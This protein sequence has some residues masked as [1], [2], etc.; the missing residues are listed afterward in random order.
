MQAEYL[1]TILKTDFFQ[2]TIEEG[3]NWSKSCESVLNQTSADYPLT[4]LTPERG[5][6][7]GDLQ[8]GLDLAIL[9]ENGEAMSHLMFALGVVTSS[10]FFYV[11]TKQRKLFRSLEEPHL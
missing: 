7:A 11:Y 10:S 4:V 5:I 2:T 3:T 8:P 1:G 9:S 6:Y